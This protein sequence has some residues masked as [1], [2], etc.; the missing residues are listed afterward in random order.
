MDS[1]PQVVDFKRRARIYP[2]SK[3]WFE[4]NT[5]TFC[6]TVLFVGFCLVWIRAVN[7]KNQRQGHF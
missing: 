2:E 5:N 1:A 3:P 4:A 6:M 7:I